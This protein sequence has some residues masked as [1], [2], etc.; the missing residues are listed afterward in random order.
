LRGKT[1]VNV[2]IT[3][4]DV[5]TDEWYDAGLAFSQKKGG[6]F[7]SLEQSAIFAYSIIRSV[8]YSLVWLFTGKARLSELMGPIGMVSTMTS[9]MQQ[10][11][12]LGDMLLY[13][14]NT[15]AF[16]SIAIGAT[17]LIPFPMLDGGRITLIGLEAVRGKPLS[18]EKEAYISMVGFV[19][20]ILLGI[21]AA[22]NDIVRIITG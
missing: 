11:P 6:F 3:P 9:A 1:E 13:L 20:I 18:Q 15:T 19:L 22:Y 21:Y 12:N 10:A 17:N 4:Q 14:M 7:E 5:K 2:T 16:M 8:G